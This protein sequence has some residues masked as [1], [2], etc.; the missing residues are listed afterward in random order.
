[1][2][3]DPTS[4]S[5]SDSAPHPHLRPPKHIGRS[6]PFERRIRFFCLLIAAPAF[7]LAAILLWQAK[8]SGTMAATLLGGAAFFSLIAASLL[9]DEIIRPLQTLANVV[10]A[11]RESDYSFRA[12]GSRQLDALGELALEIN[13]FADLLQS[14]RLDELEASALLRC[15]ISSMDAPVLAFDPEHRLRLINSAAE[16]I[17][18]L[19]AD[20]AL[21]TSAEDVRLAGLLDQPDRGIMILA[22]KGYPVHWMVR[23]S[24]FRQH[25]IP[26]TLLVLSDVSIALREQER[27]AWQRLIRVMGHE[28]NN[29]LT[30]IKSIAGSLRSWVHMNPPKAQDVDAFAGDDHLYN[31]D[32]GLR[33]IENRA[34]SLNRFIQAYRQLAQLPPPALQ[35][36]SLHPL[37]ERAVLMETRVSV[38]FKP[39]ADVLLQ[40]DA[41]QIEQLIINLLRNAAEAAL[42]RFPDAPAN[43]EVTISWKTA[44]PGVVILIEDNGIG[45]TNPSNLFV[46]FYT[47][48]PGGSGIGL[49]LARQI[50][51]AHGGVLQVANRLD[52][53][54]C[55]AE[56]R[57]PLSPS[58][59]GLLEPEPEAAENKVPVS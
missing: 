27:D 13:E 54:G 20:R 36:V 15:V 35:P 19:S 12:R 38:Q 53:P 11:L 6:A 55:G 59:R 22:G 39:G 18:H 10:S 1:M 33:I 51:E 31:L 3:S 44:P 23:R 17:F 52:G 26:H 34:E 40:L 30:P 43:C 50:C 56:I 42:A 32:R 7:V 45:L 24:T 5:G 2:E 37:V 47:T 58:S 57:L 28:I 49:A 9:M 21:G 29:S 4:H 41:D 16:R 25:G 8:V 46:P 48:K 14:Q